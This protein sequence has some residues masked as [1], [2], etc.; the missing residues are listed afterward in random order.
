M[1]KELSDYLRRKVEEN[2]SLQESIQRPGLRKGDPLREY[3]QIS[4]VVL[5]ASTTLES[6]LDSLIMGQL[7]ALDSAEMKYLIENE[8]TG[9]NQKM[10]FLQFAGVIDGGDY[11][12]LRILFD[13][14]NSFAHK[15]F[16][17]IDL[18]GIFSKM[19]S[20]RIQDG[21]AKGMPNDAD[22]F[23][24]LANFHARRLLE[25]GRQGGASQSKSR[26]G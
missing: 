4:S 8:D 16:G 20:L 21:I 13:I 9:V 24:Y 26:K 2:R 22:K 5:I 3:G 17:K 11:R 15:F 25:K 14:R 10:R 18:V 19:D 12:D 1:D 23:L 7:V 6:T